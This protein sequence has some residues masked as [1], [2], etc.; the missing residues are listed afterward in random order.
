[1]MS[2]HHPRD[3]LEPAQAGQIKL[4]VCDHYCGVEA[5]MKKSVQ[6][7]EELTQEFGVCVFDVTLDCEDGAPVG[8]ELEHAQM[9][10]EMIHSAK[11]DARIGVRVH[12]IHHP[13]FEQ[14]VATILKTAGRKITHLMLPKVDTYEELTQALHHVN[15]A[16]GA[17]T[18]IHILVESPKAIANVY[19]MA[20]HP[21]VHSISFGVMDFVSTHA[22]AIPASA[23]DIEGQFT[24]PL[25]LR[26][27][28][29]IA[30]ACHA[31]GKVPSHCV[32]TEYKNT[33]ALSHAARKA[34]QELGFTRMWSIHPDQIRPIIEAFAPKAEDVERAAAIILQAQKADWAPISFEKQLHD[35]ASYRFFWNVLEKAH[36]TGRVLPNE[37]QHLFHENH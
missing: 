31:N 8:G 5:R 32:V 10:T 6:L 3:I 28:L 24:H 7:Q 2:Q 37:L 4:P 14:D 34:S 18:P 21:R 1:M 13:S 36:S 27:K 33:Q 26:A 17:H 29:E 35:R 19:E 16:G 12:P 22:G 15:E 30:E 23:M 9:V 20:T 11:P 25:V